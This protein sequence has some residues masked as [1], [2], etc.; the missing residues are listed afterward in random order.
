MQCIYLNIRG[1]INNF[2]ELEMIIN[3]DKPDFVCLSE[4]HL[5]EEDD[6]NIVMIDNYKI[7][8]SDSSSRHTG[9][10]M[11]FIRNNWKYEIIKKVTLSY[12]LWY[13]VIKLK[14][15][16][17]KLHLAV[18][19]RANGYLN[20]SAKYFDDFKELMDVLCE[21]NEKVILV[22][23][24][25]LN[26]FDNNFAKLK[27]ENI[28]CD[29]GFKQL[30]NQYTRI[31][32]MSKTLI[33]F[34]IVNDWYNIIALVDT[35]IKISDH[36]SIRI[37][38]DENNAE[39]SCQKLVKYVDYNKDNF[40][41]RIIH[42]DMMSFYYLDCDFN[43][44]IFFDKLK[45]IM[46]EFI[47]VKCINFNNNQWF[48]DNLKIA[49][50]KKVSQY[51]L[52]VFSNNEREWT[53]Y[54]RLRNYYKNELNK[55]KNKYISEKI[56][57]ASDQRCMWRTIKTLVMR[58]RNK[59]IGDVIFN[60]VLFEDDYI[61]SKKF[62]EYFVSSIEEINSS[63]Q[64]KVYE[65]LI[66]DVITKFQ[67]K[68]IVYEDLKS[69]IKS[70][71]NKRDFNLMNAV[72]IHDILDLIGEN[73]VKLINQSLTCGVFPKIFKKSLIR[74][75][76]KIKNTIES[77]EFRP[78]NMITIEAKIYEK[79]VLHQ[80]EEYF[81][82]N[83]IISEQQSG[84]RHKHS[85]ESL[86]NLVIINW[87]VAIH[88]NKSIVAVFLDLRRAFETIDRNI[89]LLKLNKYGIVDIELKWFESYLSNRTQQTKVNE[90]ISTEIT[91]TLGV[92]QGTVLG[93]FLFLIYINDIGRVVKNGKLLMFAD[94]ALLYVE[95]DNVQVAANKINEDLQHL[96]NWF[97]MNKMKLNI[98]KTKC[99][100]LNSN[101]NN[102]NIK[103]D[104]NFIEQINEI[105]YLGVIIDSKLNFKSHLDYICKK[106]AKK[107]YFFRRIRNKLSVSTSIKIF[108]SIIKPHFEFCSTIMLMF[109]GEMVNRLQILQNRGMR[110]ILKKNRFVSK[111][112]LLKS[113]NWLNVNQRIKYN[114]LIF[115]FKIINRHL[116][117]Y[118]MEKLKYVGD[119]TQYNL[120]NKFDFRLDFFRNSKTQNSLF[121]KG[122]K[123]YNELP[124]ELKNEKNLFKFKKKLECYVKE[125]FN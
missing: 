123:L 76:E 65:N 85:C 37:I 73:L 84:F 111:S 117:N 88:S 72:I 103:I 27:T 74:P 120:R 13:L 15:G 22:G 16:N 11:I 31:D 114:V 89:L 61:I 70:M 20:M 12:E 67:F 94:D 100:V 1:V 26:W 32:Y 113:L 62:N 87:K 9:G 17:I 19:Y 75:I 30:V 36:E 14:S 92:P 58:E 93:V 51:K 63:I 121:Y 116:P 98:D 81:E 42:S 10:V 40:R 108:N 25:N 5:V 35:D 99:M 106:I 80:L 41:N 3:M 21:F 59:E 68:E 43:N 29:S 8:R 119:L 71:N 104:D 86:I 24:F 69:V 53:K 101:L 50:N 64:Y 115:V 60:N 66:P 96:S 4:T 44:E 122:L 125:N 38:I 54:R 23:D 112:V 82:L 48:S 2:N 90:V 45:I 34:V 49:K 118:L 39:D 109:N 83:N 56:D 52:A 124:I 79:I 105:K 6:D 55:E 28:I 77:S 18:L 33:D 95:S 57:F 107:L 7:V 110:I 47:L 91:T 97:K 102:C 46:N 78:V